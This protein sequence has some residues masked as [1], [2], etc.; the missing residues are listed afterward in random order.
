MYV[1]GVRVLIGR[2][3]AEGVRSDPAFFWDG[4]VKVVLD[5]FF[6]VS[7]RMPWPEF[8][9]DVYEGQGGGSVL[10]RVFLAWDLGY[11]EFLG[12]ESAPN[13]PWVGVGRLALGVYGVLRVALRVRRLGVG[14]ELSKGRL[15]DLGGLSFGFYY[16]VDVLRYLR[17]Y[18]HL[19]RDLF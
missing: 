7:V 4:V 15:K 12:T 2:G 18:L 9:Y 13:H 1:R 3:G 6:L 17:G 8:H 5:R 14:N 10:A 19:I 11:Q 16:G